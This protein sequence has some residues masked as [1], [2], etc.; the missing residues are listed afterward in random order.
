MRATYCI[1][2][3]SDAATLR[4][5]LLRRYCQRTGL[6]ASV[7]EGDDTRTRGAVQVTEHLHYVDVGCTDGPR[8]FRLGDVAEYLHAD[9]HLVANA[10]GVMATTLTLISMGE[11]L[12]VQMVL[13]PEV[14]R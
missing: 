13:L 12:R 9:L 11:A 6:A 2:G 5:L 8:V 14:V 7:V 4:R 3:W 10:L 1:S